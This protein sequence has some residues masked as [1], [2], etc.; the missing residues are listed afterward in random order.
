MCPDMILT[1]LAQLATCRTTTERSLI[2]LFDESKQYVVAEATP[3]TSL[4]PNPRASGDD[5]FWLCGTHIARTDGV[6][7][8]TL[9][10]IEDTL[11]QD[12][13][14][15]LPIVVVQ[16][17]VTDPRFISSP[18]CQPGTFARF[19]AAVPIRSPRGINIGVLCVINSTPG[20]DWH[21]EHSNVLRGLAQTV[22]DH[23]E[24]NRVKNMLKR[25]VQMSV[26]LRKFSDGRLLSSKKKSN[27]VEKSKRTENA[28]LKDA[29]PRS[30]NTNS[31][32]SNQP[33]ANSQEL[34]SATKSF[35]LSIPDIIHD[36]LKPTNPFIEAADVIKEALHIDDCAFFSGDSHDLHVMHSPETE[37]GS[38]VS[39]GKSRNPS[40]YSGEG[41]KNDGP[42]AQ[43]LLPCQILGSSA[44]NNSAGHGDLSQLLLSQM[45]KQYPE[46][47]IFDSMSDHSSKLDV[48]SDSQGEDPSAITTLGDDTHSKGVTE[49]WGQDPDE[50]NDYIHDERD[51]FN[52]FPSARSIAFIPI[53]DPQT[54]AWSIGG[55][56]SSNKPR[57]EFNTTSEMPFL[58]AIGSLA[59][60]EALRLETLADGKAK[61]DVLGSISHELRSPLHGITLGMELLNDSG[62]GPAQQD[63]AHMIE[64][65]CRTLSE[66]TEHL[67]DYSKVNKA[68][69]PQKLLNGSQ[70][71]SGPN[72]R[73]ADQLTRAVHLD[74]LLEDVIES[75]YAGHNYQYLSIAQM[76]SH[77]KSRRHADTRAI[78]RLD[79]MQ[80]AEELNPT[81]SNAK[82]QQ[83]EN[84]D[85]SVF[86]I[87][88]P[89]YSWH[90]RTLP[91][92][93]VRI[94][95]NLFGNSL[96]YTTKGL[97][98]ITMT[99]DQP[100]D[101]SNERT[102]TLVVEDTGG[103]ISEDF[104][105]NTIFK[106]FS[107]E[108]QLATGTG[109]GLSFVQRIVAQLGGRISI[110]SQINFGTKV[111]VSLPMTL[112]SVSPTRDPLA[113]QPVEMQSPC[114]GLR[115]QVVNSVEG[116]DAP[117][118]QPRTSDYVMDTLCSDSLGLKLC[119]KEDSE[120]LAPDVI[121]T[122]P[123][124][125]DASKSIRSWRELPVLVVCPNALVVHK[126]ESA[127]T[128]SG[129]TNFH[130]FVSQ[131]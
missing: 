81:G 11:H 1:S 116:V 48:L 29:A 22:M 50:T 43:S 31:L 26:G 105:R 35:C 118:R 19:Y 127:S 8:Y 57:F 33:G 36:E 123:E 13:S 77:S 38:N 10:A 47:C 85:I 17:L 41:S 28:G 56:I 3:T 16:D 78:R 40:M 66:T 70:G 126:Y 97:I 119:S 61:S 46:G 80:A 23:L 24:G 75:V 51:I 5:V 15:E 115:V 130:G 60:S 121:M 59:A 12:G 54:G 120:Q 88:D 21:E 114:R 124:V 106:P 20:A 55:F 108:D 79:S 58:R 103:G 131:P 129:H 111:T 76:F 98:K 52:V 39:S 71:D 6:C 107:Q 64:T 69:R 84:K 25:N 93:I 65:C 87:Y 113:D 99:Q 128:P 96:K 2:S 125:Y 100:K 104:L 94:V 18:Y 89:A 27:T 4:I 110:M 92:A 109:L 7:D 90:F 68:A 30:E 117:S 63:L 74:L 49:F 122:N 32:N 67:L 53:W 83:L 62:L 9:R 42:S 44:K 37:S 82:Q 102:V 86:L 72:T 112:E 91:G 45:L 101:D 14:D 73:A 34:T 95:M